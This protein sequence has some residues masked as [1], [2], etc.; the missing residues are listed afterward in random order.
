M[1]KWIVRAAILTG[2]LGFAGA[3]YILINLFFTKSEPATYL[4]KPDSTIKKETA[5]P[6][7]TPKKVEK[8]REKPV[9]KEPVQ[10]KIPETI[11]KKL[12]EEKPKPAKEIP[13][14]VL[15]PEKEEEKDDPAKRWQTVGENKT[16]NQV[17]LDE[18]MTQ[19]DDEI[20][21]TKSSSNCIKLVISKHG[22]NATA[23][24]QIEAY[25]KRERYVIAGKETT[26]KKLSG[27]RVNA[28]GRCI[29]MTIGSF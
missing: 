4:T 27:V 28:T 14:K 18:V 25:I 21:R 12:Q 3:I 11:V 26:L 7:E 15:P 22:N 23:V 9:V 8:N 2:L 24:E 29:V 10:D 20:Y 16:L 17:E 6:I 5:R 19:L 1:T 13:V